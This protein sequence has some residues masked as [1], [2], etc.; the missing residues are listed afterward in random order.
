MVACCSGGY[1]QVTDWEMAP[2]QVETKRL[3]WGTGQDEL[4]LYWG[5]PEPGS[6][7]LRLV[8]HA[9]SAAPAVETDLVVTAR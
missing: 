5:P 4:T 3:E 8:P 2:G 6:Y 1:G 9:T 7:R